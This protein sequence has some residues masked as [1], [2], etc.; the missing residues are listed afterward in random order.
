MIS[1]NA[2]LLLFT[3]DENNKIIISDARDKGW[4]LFPNWSPSWGEINFFAYD[5]PT[6]EFHLK[7]NCG[8]SKGYRLIFQLMGNDEY[9][10]LV[11]SRHGIYGTEQELINLL[12]NDFLLC[13]Q[14][15]T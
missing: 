2:K 8:K 14:N 10:V 1:Q 12:S 15:S 11:F 9:L 7:E 13:S 3:R 5:M 6:I 4:G